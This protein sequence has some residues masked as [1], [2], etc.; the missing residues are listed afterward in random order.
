MSQISE[1]EIEDIMIQIQRMN[2]NDTKDVNPIGHVEGPSKIKEHPNTFEKQ[3]RIPKYEPR[4]TKIEQLGNTCVYQ[5][6]DC[7][8]YIKTV[9][10]KLSQA[11]TLYFMTQGTNWDNNTKTQIMIGTLTGCV[12]EL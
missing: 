2:L 11:M 9:L 10:N 12:R 6:I 7:Q 5:D 8:K 3:Y 4:E 1:S